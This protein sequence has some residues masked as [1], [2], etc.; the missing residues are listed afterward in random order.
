MF[1]PSVV[2]AQ[3]TGNIGVGSKVTYRNQPAVV[4]T[5]GVGP[6]GQFYLTLNLNGQLVFNIPLLNVRAVRA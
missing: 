1:T 3:R 6:G 4:Q 5:T 2:Q